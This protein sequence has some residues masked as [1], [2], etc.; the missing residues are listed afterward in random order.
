MAPVLA[1]AAAIGGV[2]GGIEV[3]VPTLA[4]AHHKPAAAGVL[5]AMISIGGIV[6]AAAYGTRQWTA[7]PAARLLALTSAMTACAA[8]MIATEGLVVLGLVLLIAGVALNPALTTLTLLVDRLTEEP[9]RGR[10]IRMAVDRDL[11]RYRRGGSDRRR[12]R[13][14]RRQRAS[15]VRR[16]GRRGGLRHPAGARAPP[17]RAGPLGSAPGR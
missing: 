10:G 12:V 9:D 6:G 2:I 5:I 14:A 1:A 8:V 15:G 16:R 4:A 17:A 13:P 3:G 7:D 11:G